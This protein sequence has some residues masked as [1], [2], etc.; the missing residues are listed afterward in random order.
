MKSTKLKLLYVI[1]SLEVGGAESQMAMLASTLAAQGHKCDVFAL[2]A[3]GPL[4]AILLEAGV[5]IHDG[6]F[7][8]S[9]SLIEKSFSLLLALC[10]LWLVAA[11]FRPNVI[12][13]YLPFTNFMGAVAGKCAFV[14]IV[15]TSRR[16][17]GNHQNSH[18]LWKWIDQ[19]SNALSTRVTVNSQ[20]VAEDTVKRDGIKRTKI[21]CIYNGL[22][23]SRFQVEPN[24]RE[25]IRIELGVTH[26]EFLWV[27]VANLI[28]YKGHEDLLTAFAGLADKSSKLILVGQ[29]RGIQNALQ[30]Q[31]EDL[32]LAARV[33]F[34]GLRSDIPQLLSAMDGY[35]MA[36]HE[37]GF[38]NAILEAMAA[39][40]PIVATDVGGNREALQ[41]GKLGLVVPA[42]DSVAML[43]AMTQLMVDENFRSTISKEAASSV[44]Q[45]Y[46]VEMM[47]NAH[48][49]LYKSP[50]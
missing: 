31:A 32:G 44:S 1:G 46:S 7:A 41:D 29:D 35:V 22:D 50:L 43:K 6:K 39:G 20:A 18:V 17:L 40:L 26:G 48:L 28:F 38:S 21:L 30:Q 42:R 15:I 11:R 5:V 47:V 4:R 19:I 45:L 23:L 33:V 27:K 2:E 8:F 37:E 3:H 34:L 10:K 36:S 13:A 16:G 25:R 12:H 14:P 24:I 9:G 49:R